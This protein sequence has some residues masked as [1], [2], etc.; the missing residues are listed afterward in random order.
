MSLRLVLLSKE[1]P[2]TARRLYLNLCTILCLGLSFTASAQTQK[3][4]IRPYAA[5]VSGDELRASFSGQTHDGAYNF[6]TTGE[7]GQHYEESHA[8]G[9]DVLYSE[10]GTTA[11]GL[12]DIYK[13]TLCYAYTNTHMTGGCFRVYRVANCY[14]FYSAQ[15]TEAKDEINRDY[16]TARSVIKGETPECEAAFS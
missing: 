3:L 13:D 9:G 14:Y 12:W 2:L 15:I 5:R 1:R 4:D 8:P 7:P 6:S 10:R 11:D 16:W